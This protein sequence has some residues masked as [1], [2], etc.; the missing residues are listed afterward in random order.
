M[1]TYF[2]FNVFRKTI[3][4][5]FDAFND[6]K[7][8]RYSSDGRTIDRW[9]TVPIKHSVKEKVYYWLQD[10][11]R[12]D[13]EMLPMIT[14]YISAIDYAADRKVNSFHAFTADCGNV[15]GSVSGRSSVSQYLHP[16]PY[17]L[18]FTM[19]I[20][21]LHMTDVDQIMEQI[22]PFFCPHIF[23]RIKLDDLNLK[24]TSVN[25]L[26]IEFDAKIIFRSATPEVSHEMADIEY[27]VINYTL[28]FEVQ[29]WFFKPISDVGLI[30]KIYGSYFTDTQSF[31]T[32]INSTDTTFTSGASGTPGARGITY[33]IK[34]NIPSGG[35][36]DD[37]VIKYNLFEPFSSPSGSYTPDN[38]RV[39]TP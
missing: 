22:L 19:N 2:F 7:I 38:I 26:G 18:T 35:S 5:F 20:W 36:V 1:K 8:A 16:C 15:D 23:V 13:D 37:P 14:A 24:P 6:I 21:A 27:R 30:E 28:D 10:G 34:G 29:T 4:Q 33:E 11:E 17:N 32:Y 31:R 39:V 12:K 9:I 25:N 3:I